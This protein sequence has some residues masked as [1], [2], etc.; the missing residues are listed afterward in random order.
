MWTWSFTRFLLIGLA[1]GLLIGIPVRLLNDRKGAA[2]VEKARVQVEHDQV[3]DVRKYILDAARSTDR[4]TMWFSLQEAID[5]IETVHALCKDAK[6]PDFEQRFNRLR[7][8][9]DTLS[10]H[11]NVGDQMYPE[12]DERAD[13]E[14]MARA[15]SMLVTT[16]AT[17]WRA[18]NDDT[19]AIICNAYKGDP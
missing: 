4:N 6:E 15:R 19:P 8:A 12:M 10:L 2:E 3:A 13:A 14:L 18:I 11:P 16:G 9:R 17:D 5:G 7:D 1:A